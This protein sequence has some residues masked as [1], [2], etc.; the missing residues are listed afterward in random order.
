MDTILDLVVLVCFIVIYLTSAFNFERMVTVH[1][2]QKSAR[3]DGEEVV[4]A[5]MGPTGAGKS[6]FIQCVTG[7]KDVRIGHTLSS[8]NFHYSA[9]LLSDHQAETNEVFAY[10]FPHK[11]KTCI[12]VDTPGFD[13]TNRADNKI[14]EAILTWLRD[15]MISGQ[16]LNG[17]IYL[18]RIT[19]PRMG[20]TAV[21]NCR[22]F[23]K[24]VGDNSFKNVILATTFWEEV[25]EAVGAKREENLRKNKD[26]WG[27]M[28]EKGAKIARLTQDKQAG[29]SIIERISANSKVVVQ[30]Q[31]EMVNQGKSIKETAAAREQRKQAEKLQR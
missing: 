4:I 14:T 23:R 21:K 22:M 20:G 2:S 15:S 7:R 31:D 6:S 27:A 16:R 25:S 11:G 9:C 19:D 5:V 28:L 24:L 1:H 10:K 12:L 13:D 17:V 8:G 3:R 18:H 29:L 30:A 26:F